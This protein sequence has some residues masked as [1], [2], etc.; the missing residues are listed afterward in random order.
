VITEIASMSPAAVMK[1]AETLQQFYPDDLEACLVDEC[2]HYKAHLHSTGKTASTSLEMGTT[3]RK[4]KELYNLYPNIEIAL[5]M[6]L[7]TPA[8]NCSA[9]RSFS[10]LK[11]VKNYLRSKM[12]DERLTNLAVLSI[13]S[14]LL[15]SLDYDDIIN[16]FANANARRKF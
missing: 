5:R 10:C 3:M 15:I 16:S 4:E 7:C 6:Y 14:E 13:E 9:E 1:Q 12:A 8:T 2:I 11:R